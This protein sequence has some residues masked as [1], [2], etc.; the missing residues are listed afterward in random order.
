[1]QVGQFSAICPSSV[2]NRPGQRT[3]RMRSALALQTP[4]RTAGNTAAGPTAAAS[5]PPNLPRPDAQAEAFTV[6]TLSCAIA[7]PK[8]FAPR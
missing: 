6:R 8:A 1:M 4:R 7:H 3:G 5:L 2:I